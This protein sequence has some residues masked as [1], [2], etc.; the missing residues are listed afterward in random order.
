M[1]N[2]DFDDITVTKRLALS[3]LATISGGVVIS[4]QR[5]TVVTIT[6]SSTAAASQ[7]VLADASSGAIQVNLPASHSSGDVIDV[8]KIDNSNNVTVDGNGNNIDGSSD[9]TLTIQYESYC[10]VSDGTNWFMI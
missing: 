9:V 3:D 1:A 2:I 10:F 8:K 7:V 6:S 4:T 5:R